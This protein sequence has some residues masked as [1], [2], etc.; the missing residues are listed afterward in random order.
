[1]VKDLK[2]NIKNGINK[3]RINT[4]NIKQKSR[5]P[6]SFWNHINQMQG[7]GKKNYDKVSIEVDGEITSEED[8]VEEAFGSSF[9]SKVRDLSQ[10][11]GPYVWTKN[12]KICFDMSVGFFTKFNRLDLVVT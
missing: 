4:I 12:S 11:E 9:S 7:K 3:E 10:N 8:M 5:N 6:K 2:K 1:M